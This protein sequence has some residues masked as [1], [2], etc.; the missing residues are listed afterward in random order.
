MPSKPNSQ[1]STPAE[2]F[3]YIKTLKF[4]MT[5]QGTKITARE[6]PIMPPGHKMWFLRHTLKSKSR[7]DKS[8][9]HYVWYKPVPAPKILPPI[10]KKLPKHLVATRASKN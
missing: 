9:L 8:S 2:E 1:P 6:I 3:Q 10:R 4:V 7:T 5:P